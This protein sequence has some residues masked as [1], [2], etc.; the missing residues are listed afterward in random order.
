MGNRIRCQYTDNRNPRKKK[1]KMGEI[2]KADY[3]IFPW[4]TERLKILNPKIYRMQNW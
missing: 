1:K 4:I 2:L 3:D